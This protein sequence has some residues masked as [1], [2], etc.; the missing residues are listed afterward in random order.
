MNFGGYM[1]DVFITFTGRAETEIDRIATEGKRSKKEVI[2]DA[3]SLYIKL[4]RELRENPK[5][6]LG[7]LQNN[8]VVKLIT[9]PLPRK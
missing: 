6:Q 8:K 7:I 9:S 2:T 3:L 4:G 1:V 5:A